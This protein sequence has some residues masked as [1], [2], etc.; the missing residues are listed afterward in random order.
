MAFECPAPDTMDELSVTMNE[1]YRSLLAA[2][3]S[4]HV[5][6]HVLTSQG[7]CARPTPEA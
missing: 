3:F 5:A 6:L 2:G 1:F 4:E 7:C